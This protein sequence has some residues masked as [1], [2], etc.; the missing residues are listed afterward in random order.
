[1][2]VG[3]STTE[4]G[5][6]KQSTASATHSTS[7]GNVTVALTTP[8]GGGFFSSGQL[9]DASPFTYAQLYNDYAFH[10]NSGAITVALTGAGI[11][12]STQYEVTLYSFDDDYSGSADFSPVSPTTGNSRSVSWTNTQ[13]P[14]TDDRYAQTLTLTSDSTGK[15]SFKVDS[16]GWVVRL[17]GFKVAAPQPPQGTTLILDNKSAGVSASAGWSPA[18]SVLGYHDTDYLHDNNG[19]KTTPRTVFFVPSFSA[20][21]KYAV[22]LR[23]TAHEN[24]AEHVPVT[25]YH[26]GPEGEDPIEVNQR[27][28]GGQW[29]LLGTYDFVPGSGG[30]EVSNEGTTGYVIADA[31]KFEPAP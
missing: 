10:N 11:A 1:V 29:V 4:T 31:V 8:S 22:Y 30:V 13:P 9:S 16:A 6:V 19:G 27:L 20:P 2:D 15:L 21:G 23:W 14:T 24:R 18:S 26:A 3:T 28:T 12:A 25:V 5:F 7:R 17:C